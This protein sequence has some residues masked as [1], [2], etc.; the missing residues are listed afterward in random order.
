[1]IGFLVLALLAP[2]TTCYAVQGAQIR[3]G[4]LA[5]AGVV[6][7]AGLDAGLVVG[8]APSGN[9]RRTVNGEELSRLARLNGFSATAFAKPV[10][11][12]RAAGVVEKGSLQRA[13]DT[14]LN[15]PDAQLEIV[16]FTRV[17]LPQGKLQFERARLMAPPEAHPDAPVLWH[18]Q[19]V[20][21]GGQHFPFWARVRV[22]VRQS[23]VVTTQYLAAGSLLKPSDLRVEEY[24]GFPLTLDIAQRLEQVAGQELQRAYRAGSALKITDIAAP[25]DVVRG[26]RVHVSVANGAAR[27][28]L[29][30]DARGRG[31]VGDVIQVSNPTTKKMF[32]A[33]ISGKDHVEVTEEKL[34]ASR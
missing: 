8:Y 4:D 7:A 32:L 19:V 10:C 30:G 23:R 1:M 11:F 24:A 29:E 25:S 27:L 15:L 28:E 2:K 31:H 5:A 12:V 22:T 17:P 33:R 6:F 16:D 34:R 26:A 21:D 20:T 9:A 14:A 13:L 3:M 18:G